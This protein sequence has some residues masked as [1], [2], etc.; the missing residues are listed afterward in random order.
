M[1]HHY[2]VGYEFKVDGNRLVGMK[3]RK[4]VETIADGLFLFVLGCSATGAVVA[5]YQIVVHWRQSWKVW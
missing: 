3:W 2:D 4:L 5:V 1:G